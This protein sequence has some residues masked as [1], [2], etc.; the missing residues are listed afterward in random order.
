MLHV[1]QPGELGVDGS[2]EDQDPVTAILISRPEPQLKTS[3]KCSRGTWLI[4][5]NKTKLS[6]SNFLAPEMI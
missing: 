6:W 3:G 1:T 5:S 2:P 4:K